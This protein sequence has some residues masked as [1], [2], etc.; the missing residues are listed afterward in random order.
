MRVSPGQ[1]RVSLASAQAQKQESDLQHKE[2]K[3]ARASRKML[4]SL[5]R[6]VQQNDE[7]A[8]NWALDASRRET[9]KARTKALDAFS[10]YDHQRTYKQLRKE[11][12]PGTSSWICE[13]DEFQKWMNGLGRTFW[14]TGKRKSTK[15][16]AIRA[17]TFL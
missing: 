12:V 8:K 7:E 17:L 15:Q 3:A 14:C 10:V 5:S 9:E 1:S 16:Y 11:C 6:S 2:R 13:T 4:T